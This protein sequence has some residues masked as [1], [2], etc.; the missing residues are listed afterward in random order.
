MTALRLAGA[1]V[2]CAG[3][4]LAQTSQPITLLEQALDANKSAEVAKLEGDLL[5]TQ[6]SESDLLAAGGLLGQHDRLRDAA[7]LFERCAQLYP[8]SF[9]ARYDLALA[10]I[11]LADYEGATAALQG[12]SPADKEQKA[13]VA[14]L[15]GK[16][17]LDTNRL[18]EAQ[19]KLSEANT[20]APNNENYA[21]DLG[22]VYIHSSAY[23][24]AVR[25]LEQALRSHRESTE[26]RLELALADV[27]AGL[28]TNAISLCRELVKEDP[29]AS[30]PRVI[31]AFSYCAR[32][33]LE[34]CE[35]EATTGL[36][37]AHPHPYLYYLRARARWDNGQS[38]P[39]ASL[40]DLSKAIEQMPNCGVCLLLRSRVYEADHEDSLALADGRRAVVVNPDSASAWYRLSAL[41]R[42]SG[43]ST[44]A[45]N[46][47]EHYRT[48]HDDKA[49]QEL[50]SFRS[51]FLT[52]QA[53][54]NPH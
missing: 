44:E 5:A 45:A 14:Y 43:N 42:K 11:G 17:F 9:E 38:N 15:A 54:T 28:N 36:S 33:E 4:M 29:A 3:L 27:L 50:E 52:A 40:S 47:L 7:R 53:S 35:Q 30:L 34:A 8:A 1:T 24:L 18:T 48:I 22:L 46:A 12:L 26:L 19:A 51:Q 6:A 25:E 32:G 23:E 20:L 16:I 13:S 2:F 31:A 10:R 49:T 39:G 41:E 21:L 37:G